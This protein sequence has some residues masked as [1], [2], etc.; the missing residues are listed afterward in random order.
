MSERGWALARAVLLALAA[1][2]LS[3]VSPLVLVTVP[4]AL[5]LLAFRPDDLRAGGAAILILVL[6]FL[7]PAD[8]RDSLWYVER[9]WALLA[10]GGFV[11]ATLLAGGRS[12]LVGRGILGV[13]GGLVG[14]GAVTL[15]R[16]EFP[17]RIDAWIGGELERAATEAYQLVGSLGGGGLEQDLGW[18]LF[19]WV[20]FQVE[21]YPA[22]LA[23]ATVASLGVGWYVVRRLAGASDA[24]PPLRD[25]RFNDQMVWVLIGGLV[26]LLVPWGGLWSRAGENAVLFMGGIY[27]LRGLAVMLWIAAATVSSAWAG[28]LWAAAGLL[29][30]PL[31]AGAALVLGLCDTWLD[32]RGRFRTSSV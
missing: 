9:G 4:L 21:V 18:A 7:G 11:A 14:V 31:A 22:L 6:A 29:L 23:L 16:P 15:F 5:L 26:L 25:F 20:E 13:A 27:L 1:V 28:A 12:S 17:G 8:G 19:D 2:V 3:P 30:Y 10:G 32:I 24:L